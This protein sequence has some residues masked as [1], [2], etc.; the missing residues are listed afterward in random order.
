[1][2]MAMAVGDDGVEILKLAEDMRNEDF[3]VFITREN[4]DEI[5]FENGNKMLDVFLQSGLIDEKAYANGYGRTTPT[6]VAA[7]LRESSGKREELKRRQEKQ[8]QSEQ[9]TILQE[10]QSQEERNNQA[11]ARDKQER[12][13]DKLSDQEHDLNK[14]LVK[15]EID[16][17]SKINN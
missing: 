14:I 7:I 3:R 6:G 1:M 12:S 5:L 11:V 13:V 4:A 2:E 17:N 16:A 9:E 8:A 10:A 15:G